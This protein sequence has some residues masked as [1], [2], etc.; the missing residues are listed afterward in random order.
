MSKKPSTLKTSSTPLP[1]L[2]VA[3]EVKVEAPKVAEEP[4]A[5]PGSFASLISQ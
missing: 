5:R 3:E 1:K 2:E 4:K